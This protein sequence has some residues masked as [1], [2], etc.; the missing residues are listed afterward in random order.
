MGTAEQNNANFR[1][2]WIKDW[3]QPWRKTTDFSADEQSKVDC[4]TDEQKSTEMKILTFNVIGR[5]KTSPLSESGILSSFL[6]VSK[7]QISTL[8]DL[9]MLASVLIN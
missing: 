6:T 5:R 8:S 9:R 7:R 1:P 3:L 4:G 2:E